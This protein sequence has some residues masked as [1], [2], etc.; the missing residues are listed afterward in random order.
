M[1]YT[2]KWGLHDR[3]TPEGIKFVDK[4][5]CSFGDLFQILSPSSSLFGGGGGCGVRGAGA[6]LCTTNRGKLLQHKLIRAQCTKKH[7]STGIP[8]KCDNPPPPQNN[9]ELGLGV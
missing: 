6:F 5:S 3:H 8:C 7:P 2:V 4:L 9:E 1:G